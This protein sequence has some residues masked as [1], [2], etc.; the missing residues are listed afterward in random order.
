MKSLKS[1]SSAALLW[2]LAVPSA[3]AQSTGGSSAAPSSGAPGA[4][5]EIVVTAEKRSST[6]QDTPISISARSGEELQ[7]SG[8]TDLTGVIHEVPGISVRTS[9][10]GQTELEMRGLSSSGGA[11]PTVGFYLNDYPLSPPAAALVGKVV[12]DPDLFDLTRVEVL[13]GPQGTLYG[14][15][16]MG[17]TVKLVT[18]APTLNKFNAAVQGAASETDGGGF[19]RGGNAMLNVPLVDDRAAM[20]VVFTSKVTDGFIDRVVL[21]PFPPPVNPGPACGPGWPGCVR[22]DVT[23]ATPTQTV[24]HSNVENLTGGR[25]ELAV[26]PTDRLQV[27]ALVMLQ[28]IT[29]SGYSEYDDPPGDRLVHYQPFSLGEPFSDDFRLFGVTATYDLGFAKLT[30]ASAFYSRTESQEQDD[31]E[32]LYSFFPLFAIPAQFLP[33][34]FNE[35]DTTQQLSEELRLTSSSNGPL[36]WIVGAFYSRFESTF[37]EYSA[38]RSVAPFS[39]GG[40]PANPLGIIYQAHNPYHMKQYAIFGESTYALTEQFKLTAGLRW[41][42]FRSSASEEVS[43]VATG[44]GNGSQAVASFPASNSGLNP[45]V[46]LSY[47]TN[48]EL[49]LYAT[50]ARGFRPGGINQ[51]IPASLCTLTTETYGPDSTWNYEVGEKAKL[52]GGRIVFNSDFYYIRW[53]QVQQT[54]N[55]ACGYPLTVN[56]GDAASYGP[57]V[58]LW[59]RVTPELSAMLNGTYTH[60]ELTSVAGSLTATTGLTSGTTLINVPKYTATAA[61]MYTKPLWDDKKLSVRVSDSYVGSSRDI[62]FTSEQLAPYNLIG[63][64]FGVTADKWS[65]FLFGDNLTNKRAELGVNTSSFAFQAPSLVRVATNQPRTIGVDLSYRF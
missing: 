49:T 3:F 16:S 1:V 21:N 6:I 43:G 44:T 47:E 42:Q 9:G 30:S 28:R 11:A 62:A 48:H 15:G 19:N 25:A 64:R 37:W 56:A 57:E 20:R 10:P 45:K 36:Q 26:F 60:A 7:Q 50:A 33:I 12:V 23:G 2:V 53:S 18:N 4:V 13:R 22:G 31:A 34:L 17:G 63:A 24:K 58:E 40:A 46:T 29:D 52:A 65:A 27:E 39:L 32:A 14:S 61:L 5:E 51:Q 8:I 54:V 38:A 35:T 41:Y 59:A 55:Q